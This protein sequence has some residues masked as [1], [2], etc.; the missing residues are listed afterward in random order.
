MQASVIG[1]YTMSWLRSSKVPE[2]HL[3]DAGWWQSIVFFCFPLS[4][5]GSLSISVSFAQQSRGATTVMQAQ[6]FN[7]T[8]LLLPKTIFLPLYRPRVTAPSHPAFPLLSVY[9]VHLS[10]HC[11]PVSFPFLPRF[12]IILLV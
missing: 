6:I 5:S 8:S 4:S 12:D 1:T 11:P 9:L 2:S 7:W 10:V 3:L